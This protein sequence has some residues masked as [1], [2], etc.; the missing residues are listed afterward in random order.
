MELMKATMPTLARQRGLS[1]LYTLVALVALALAAVALV[2]SVSTSSIVAGNL[3]F[4]QDATVVADRAVREAITKLDGKLTGN[5]AGLDANDPAI[6]YYASVDALTDVTN[7]QSAAITR[8]LVDW[9]DACAS[10]T[11]GTYASCDFTSATSTT[12]TGALVGNTAKYVIFRM[13]DAAG[14]QASVNCA[15]PLVSTTTS[16][17][18]ETTDYRGGGGTT[19]TAN[20]P[21]Y[22][23]VVRVAGARNTVSYT[24]TIVHF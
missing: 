16:G 7:S 17:T 14:G 19:T 8:K 20:L 2:R 5:A 12:V 4:K 10:Q 15:R 6:G 11:V 23:I 9:G 13:C 1:L 18:N 21:Y 22:R 3:A 24:E